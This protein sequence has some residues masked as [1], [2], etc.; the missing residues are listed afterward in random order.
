ME[1]TQSGSGNVEERIARLE[2]QDERMARVLELL[3]QQAS[4]PPAKPRRNWDAYAAVI[5]S[6]IGLLALGVSAY[7]A[8]V[9]GQQ[10][11]AQVWPYLHLWHSNA[12]PGWYVT[13]VGTGPAL[14]TGA[15]VKVDGTVVKTWKGFGSAAGI[16]EDFGSSSIGDQVLP[17]D[18][19]YPLLL[20]SENELSR[21]KFDELLRGAHRVEM[22]I[23]YCSILEECWFVDPSAH[24]SK[25]ISTD[26][27]PILADDRFKD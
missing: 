11:R 3:A 19:D 2:Q 7:T 6:L 13:N 15:R 17:P 26:V 16:D 25:A 27:C 1:I 9:Q 5:A 12:N 24:R 4:A 20:P 21:K 23:C 10:L 22:A 18:K 14:I 8:H